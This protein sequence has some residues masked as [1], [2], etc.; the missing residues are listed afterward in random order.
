M[1]LQHKRTYFSLAIFLV[2]LLVTIVALQF[3]ATKQF[4][5]KLG[6]AGLWGAFVGGVLY[7][8]A[9]T[10]SLATAVFF[11][12]AA[13]VHPLLLAIAGG[14]GSAIYDL[15]VFSLIRRESHRSFLESF[16]QRFSLERRLPAWLLTLIGLAIIASPLPDELAAGLLGFTDVSTKKF[17]II[18][19]LANTAGIL[20][21]V[22]VS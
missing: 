22:S 17:V 11:N 19:F 4:I 3:P 9:F 13:G 2:G 21:I 5:T 20:F 14:L 15:T 8:F 1:H 16:R 12:H 18:S 6:Q 7:A 10:S